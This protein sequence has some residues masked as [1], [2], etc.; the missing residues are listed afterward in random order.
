[1]TINNPCPDTD[2]AITGLDYDYLIYQYEQAPE[3]GMVHL[4]GYLYFKN[5]VTFKKLKDD[6]PTAH[7]E[8]AR[9][10]ATNN[11]DY[12]SK[13]E[14][15]LD[16]PYEYGSRPTQGKRTDLQNVC[17]SLR[18]GKSVRDVL[19]SDDCKYVHIEKYVKRIANLLTPPRDRSV[20]PYVGIFWGDSG[21]GK[22]RCVYDDY[23]DS[24]FSVPYN[25]GVKWYDGYVGQRCILFDDWPVDTLDDK[26]LYNHL[27]TVTDRYTTEVQTKGGFSTLGACDIVFTSNICPAQWFG[28]LGLRALTRRITQIRHFQCDSLFLCEHNVPSQYNNN[29]SFF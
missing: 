24:V 2:H 5:K 11:I 25:A 27:L 23:K 26:S 6:L 15:R 1:M 18:S 29:N 21:V 17:V 9:G 3:T 28:G 13:I 12:C 22:T 19:L 4:Q 7:L 16:G 8:F 10:S 20:A 14:S